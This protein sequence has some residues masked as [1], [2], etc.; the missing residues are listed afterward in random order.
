MRRLPGG[1]YTDHG[2]EQRL[3]TVNPPQVLGTGTHSGIHWDFA[4]HDR[5]G[6]ALGGR[7]FSPQTWGLG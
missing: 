3:R 1:R 6:L 4:V 2:N 7:P 5:T